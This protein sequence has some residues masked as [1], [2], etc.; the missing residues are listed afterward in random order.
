MKNILFV[1][2]GP[3]GAGKDYICNELERRMNIVR[4]VSYTTRRIRENEVDGVDYHYIS[5]EQFEKMIEK[6]EF[7]EYNRYDEENNYGTRRY[8][9]SELKG[10]DIL[11]R[12]DVKGE[13]IEAMKKNVIKLQGMK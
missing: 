3:S 8:L 11:F 6:D 9:E 10:R 4:D 7:L 12:K 2:A 1:I 5:K 13:V